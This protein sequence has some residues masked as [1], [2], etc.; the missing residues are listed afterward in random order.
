[1]RTALSVLSL[2]ILLGAAPSVARAQE[3]AVRFPV[4]EVGDTTF[5]FTVGAQRWVRPGLRGIVVDPRQ[6]DV[7]VARFRVSSV[8]GEAALAVITGQATTVSTAH[9]VLL[10][11]PQMPWYKQRSFWLGTAVGAVVGFLVGGL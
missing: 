3:T 7:L 5:T 10:D 11:V 6:R 1:M 4:A 8:T 2:A 9:T